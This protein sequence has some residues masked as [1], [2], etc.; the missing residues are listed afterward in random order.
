MRQIKTNSLKFTKTS[1]HTQKLNTGLIEE[2]NTL[3]TQQVLDNNEIVYD[4][5]STM[6]TSV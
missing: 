5:Y 1:R 2:T 6:T 4:C 3:V